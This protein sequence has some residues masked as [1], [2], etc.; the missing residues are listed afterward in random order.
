[1]M[2][3]IEPDFDT[4]ELG[5]DDSLVKPVS[6]GELTSVIGQ[7]HIRASYGEQL[8][9]LFRLASKKALLDERTTEAERQSSQECAELADRLAVLRARVN[10]TV[11]ELLEQGGYR[12]SCQ[13]M[14]RGSAVQE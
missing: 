3:A 4:V 13:D 6:Q 11:T 2:T 1:M 10:E 9:E 12:Q 7:L 8:R 5:F 14:A